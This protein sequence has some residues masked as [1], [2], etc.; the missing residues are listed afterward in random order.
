MSE[1]TDLAEL[2]VERFGYLFW[3]EEDESD[4]RQRVWQKKRN[5]EIAAGSPLTWIEQMEARI[6]PTLLERSV[7]ANI[8]I[9]EGS[10]LKGDTV[11]LPMWNDAM[12]PD[13]S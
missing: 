4:Y 9:V 3:D 11:T 1:L 13:A 6:L 10:T 12:R 8:T 7:F 2:A 5:A